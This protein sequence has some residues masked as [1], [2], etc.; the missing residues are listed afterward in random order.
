MRKLIMLTVAGLL[1]FTAVAFALQENEYSVTGAVLPKDSGTKKAPKPSSIKFG[2]KVQEKDGK[3][4]GLI[5][6]YDIQFAGMQVNTNFFPGCSADRIDSEQTDVNCPKGSLLGEGNVENIAGPSNDE[7]NTATKCHL[8]LK[9]YNARNNKAALYLTGGPSPAGPS[10]PDH[11]PLTIAKAIE[12]N[13][14]R[15]PVGVSLQFTVDETLLHPV[16]GFDNAVVDVNSFLPKKTKKVKG[17]TRG[18]FES[19]GRCKNKKR[20]IT[21]TFTPEN[22]TPSQTAQRLTPCTP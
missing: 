8:E 22:G 3:R 12:A 5:K 18:Y 9:V 19:I 10:D 1:A 13:F 17:K 16:G 7:A 15:S 21:V 6:K 2:Y 20:A 4:P 14:V 11:C